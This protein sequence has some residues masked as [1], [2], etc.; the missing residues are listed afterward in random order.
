MKTIPQS[1]ILQCEE[2][3]QSLYITSYIYMQNEND[4]LEI[5]SQTI[6][7]ILK[8]YKQ[9]KNPQYF[10]TWATRIL[11]NECKKE[12]KK[13]KRID[14]QD[15]IEISVEDISYLPLQDAIKK[16]PQHLQVIIE[17]KYFQEYTL[18]EISYM[19]N[20]PVTTISSQLKKA[21]NLLKI[22]LEVQD[23]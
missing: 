3:K 4:A 11:I 21:L 9:L 13:R 12:L 8:K 10:K 1:L 6:F 20:I 18:S 7:I 5:V 2:I 17:L 15:E 16:L 23:E 22:E 14:Y 19:L